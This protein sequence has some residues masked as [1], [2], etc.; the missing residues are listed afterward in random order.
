[1]CF[2]RQYVVKVP[3]IKVLQSS[4]NISPATIEE[5]SLVTSCCSTS[6]FS[7][8]SLTFKSSSSLHRKFLYFSFLFFS[9][10]SSFPKFL[11]TVL[12]QTKRS[13]LREGH[14]TQTEA[15]NSLVNSRSTRLRLRLPLF[16]RF[17]PRIGCVI[18]FRLDR[19]DVLCEKSGAQWRGRLV[20]KALGF[21][22]HLFC[23]W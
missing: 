5:S 10:C 17:Q 7:N 18:G 23:L 8:F 11:R 16:S 21:L 6:C 3:K 9:S 4:V 13:F 1:M 22:S 20:L 14:L 15:A 2:Q 12:D 19:K